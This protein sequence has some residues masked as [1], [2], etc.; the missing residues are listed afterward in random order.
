MVRNLWLQI[1][2][3]PKKV[4]VT[5]KAILMANGAYEQHIP[6]AKSQRQAKASKGPTV[7]ATPTALHAKQQG[8]RIFPLFRGYKRS[9]PQMLLMMMIVIRFVSYVLLN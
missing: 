3:H 4:T 2:L 9:L 5:G 1:V 8:E 7:T 6:L